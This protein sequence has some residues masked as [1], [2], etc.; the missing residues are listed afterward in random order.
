MGIFDS[1]KML[2]QAMQARK[3]MSQIKGVGQSGIFKGVILDGLYSVDAIEINKEELKNKLS[4]FAPSEQLIEEIAKI[5]QRD[6]KSAFDDAK[7]HVEKQMAS[8]TSLEDLKSM[9]QN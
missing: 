1:A 2:R 8:A 9:L 5:I 4:R 3:K 7:K 6:T